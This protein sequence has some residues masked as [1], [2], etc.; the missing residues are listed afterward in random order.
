M[1]HV[2]T[3]QA[4]LDHLLGD[5]DGVEALRRA[6][7]GLQ[8]DTWGEEYTDAIGQ[9]GLFPSTSWPMEQVAAFAH[10]HAMVYGGSVAECRIGTRRGPLRDAE[11]ESNAA[12]LTELPRPFRAAVSMRQNNAEHDGILAWDEPVWVT[13]A[14]EIIDHR[15]D[16][17]TAPFFVTFTIP[18]GHA[19]LEIGSSLPSR[20]LAHLTESGS[21]A[22]W[23]YGWNR[24]RLFVNLDPTTLMSLIDEY[25]AREG[26]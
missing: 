4:L 13:L 21:V 1:S 16:G 22:R 23:P 15:P 7:Q 8:D 26:E 24:I 18:P 14:T 20:T 25:R 6:R 19:V 12:I 10:V 9:H 2:D 17:T 3:A 5:A 11:R